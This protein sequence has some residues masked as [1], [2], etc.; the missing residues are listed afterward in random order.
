MN[1]TLENTLE[2]QKIQTE[3]VIIYSKSPEF[4][5]KAFDYLEEK[6]AKIKKSEDRHS[7][8]IGIFSILYYVTDPTFTKT[9]LNYLKPY[10]NTHTLITSHTTKDDS[11]IA[12]LV[13]EKEIS[14]LKKVVEELVN[15]TYKLEQSYQRKKDT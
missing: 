10:I 11:R 1:A 4:F 7:L 13:L 2:L 6:M 8:I 5:Q 12:L 15:Y 3:F 9:L 14:D